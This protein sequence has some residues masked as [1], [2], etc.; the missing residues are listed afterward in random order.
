MNHLNNVK[1]GDLLRLVSILDG[2]SVLAVAAT[3]NSISDG[4]RP[5]VMVDE[6]DNLRASY[7]LPDNAEFELVGSATKFFTERQPAYQ[8]L[9]RHLDQEI[10]VLA[11]VR[12]VEVIHSG[13]GATT[14]EAVSDAVQSA[15]N[16]GESRVAIFEDKIAKI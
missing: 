12:A 13:G 4:V 3:T 7:E 15:I 14:A 11:M 5:V 2:E 10:D 8:A 1:N 9:L 16:L 6:A